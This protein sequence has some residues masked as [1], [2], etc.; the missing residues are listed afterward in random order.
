MEIDVMDARPSDELGGQHRLMFMSE[1]EGGKGA[2]S[3]ASEGRGDTCYMQRIGAAVKRQVRTRGLTITKGLTWE[4]AKQ[5]MANVVW[6]EDLK[7]KRA[8]LCPLPCP[9]APRA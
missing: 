8:A 4:E 1:C 3:W 5:R 7:A 6:S 2:V 9:P